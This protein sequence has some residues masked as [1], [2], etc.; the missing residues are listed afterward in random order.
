MQWHGLRTT[1]AAMN[2]K[3]IETFR[4]VMLTGSMTL[5]AQ[6]LHTSQPN[7]SRIIGKLE[8]E[9]G[10]ALFDRHAGRVLPTKAAEAFFRE[11]ERAFMGLDSVA[12]SARSIRAL[13]AGTLRVAAA[14]SISMSVL[15]QAI[16]L[17]SAR[18]P[19][20]R[21]VVDTSESSVIANWV[22]TQHCDI[23]FA[24]YV[25]DKPGVV[26]TLIHSEN[27]VCVMSAQHRLAG[28]KRVTPRDLAGERFISLP[29]GTASRRAIDA[30]FVQDER[31]LAL[32]TPY[33][34]TICGLVSEGLGLSLV[35][36]IIGRA[37]HFAGVCT[38]PFKPDIPFRSYMLRAQLAPNDTLVQEFIAC[39]RT[40]FKPQRTVRA[41]SLQGA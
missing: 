36:P 3:Q 21:I 25:A 23:G 4:T 18:Y 7:V 41:D 37:L 29:N 10:F 8:A 38:V 6:Q 34:A 24:S 9:I 14:A 32:E 1:I 17:F 2:F 33:A 11:V 22:A 27:A 26:A 19:Q 15:P 20:V 35:N 13:G 16:R 30:A 28:R 5:A 39:M 12:E 31:I 40:A